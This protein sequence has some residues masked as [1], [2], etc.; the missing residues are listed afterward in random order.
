MG[1]D[2]VGANRLTGFRPAQMQYVPAGGLPPEFVIERDNA[3]HLGP[4]D[5]QRRGDQ[6]FG[7]QRNAAERCLQ[8][9]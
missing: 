9:M 6:R 2:G 7:L 8:F 3:V 1:T 5:V 4:G